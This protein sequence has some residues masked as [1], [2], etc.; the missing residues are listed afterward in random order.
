MKRNNRQVWVHTAFSFALALLLFLSLGA[1]AAETGDPEGAVSG[2]L[3]GEDFEPVSAEDFLRSVFY[4]QNTIVPR[5]VSLSRLTSTQQK[6][7]QIISAEVS[8]IYSGERESASIIIPEGAVYTMADFG[9]TDLNDLSDNDKRRIRSIVGSDLRMVIQVLYLNQRMELFWFPNAWRCWAPYVYPDFKVGLLVNPDFRKDPNDENS[10]DTSFVASAREAAAFAQGIVNRYQSSTDY[11]KLAGYKDEICALVEYDK[12]AAQNYHQ[13]YEV[14]HRTNPWNLLWVFDND[15]TTNVVCEAYAEAFQYLCDLSRFD[16]NISSITVDNES[17]RWNLVHMD[18]GLN[19]LVDV[20]MCDSTGWNYFLLPCQEGNVNDG[21]TFATDEGGTESIKRQYADYMFTLYTADQLTVSPTPYVRA[22]ALEFRNVVHPTNYKIGTAEGYS[23]SE[24]SLVSDRQLQ[25]ITTVIKKADDS[26]TI[27][28]PVT[29]NISG[30]SYDIAKLDVKDGTD[31]GVC[32]SN[33]NDPKYEGETI[34]WVLSAT[35]AG[36]RTLKLEMLF[37]ASYNDMGSAAAT[38]KTNGDHTSPDYIFLNKA[39]LALDAGSSEILIPLLYPS[40][41]AD[42][43][44][45]WMSS[46]PAVA[47]VDYM[48]R[49]T[50][51]APGTA[52]IRVQSA[53]GHQASCAVQVIAAGSCGERLTWRCPDGV[54]TISGIGDMYDYDAGN[55]APWQDLQNINMVCINDGVTKI[56]DYAFCDLFNE[57]ENPADVTIPDSVTRIGHGA[58]ADCGRLNIRCYT[59]SYAHTYAQAN[60]LPYTLLGSPY[61]FIL[62]DALEAIGEEAFSGIM[63]KRVKLP[64]N[65]AEVGPLAFAGCPN[66]IRIYI[67]GGCTAI[68]ANA[69]SGCTDLVIYGHS[70]SYAETYALRIGFAFVDVDP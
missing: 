52:T 9:I 2:S 7:Y 1:Y 55:R 33:L 41:A 31:N 68:A 69:F 3:A 50:A 66:L 57:C 5:G 17:H 51:V 48:G 24:G 12:E 34:V 56:G 8:K 22:A 32:F 43:R 15:P 64:E 14:E 38:K 59:G 25:T 19:Y 46:D 26:E 30:Y 29:R 6:L 37:T 63:A 70:G 16:A 13:I 4:P 54:L 10:F 42:Q 67:P 65:V 28:G 11:D 45:F 35:D 44:V 58:F 47:A 21:Y 23:L 36:G 49:V 40:D 62:P 20:T 18:D 60:H 39:S 27:S 53:G 61:D